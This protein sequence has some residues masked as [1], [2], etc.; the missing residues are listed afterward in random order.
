LQDASCSPVEAGVA[1][2]VVDD[3]VAA[4][5]GEA[6]ISSVVPVAVDAIVAGVDV[7]ARVSGVFDARITSVSVRTVEVS[8]SLGMVTEGL[9]V[10]N[11]AAEMVAHPRK[12]INR[13]MRIRTAV[14]ANLNRS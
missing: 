7:G 5:V 2:T 8:A 6:V 14:P 11:G 10:G 4:G 1:V 9:T 13:R 12:S 3:S